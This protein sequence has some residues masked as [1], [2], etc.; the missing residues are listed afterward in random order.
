MFASKL[1]T[2]LALVLFAETILCATAPTKITVGDE[3]TLVD[4]INSENQYFYFYSQKDGAK[5]TIS[6]DTETCDI[7]LYFR[8][9]MQQP[10]FESKYKLKLT[11]KKST[12]GCHSTTEISRDDLENN[13][14]EVV[15]LICKPTSDD[16]KTLSILVNF[17]SPGPTYDHTLLG[18]SYGNVSISLLILINVV[19]SVFYF[20]R[21]RNHKIGKAI[22]NSKKTD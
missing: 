14:P 9:G 1:F 4:V 13:I 20:R 17:D 11:Q 6:A 10:T 3:R 7:E 5:Y 8:K 19:I 18:L 15:Q 2:I 21:D 12:L 16:I 22:Q